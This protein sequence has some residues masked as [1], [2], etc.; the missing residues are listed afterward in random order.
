[1][2]PL[3]PESLLKDQITALN[4]QA[5]AVAQTFPDNLVK[6]PRSDWP[7]DAP[8]STDSIYQ[9]NRYYVQVHSE[10]AGVKRLCICKFSLDENAQAHNDISFSQIMGIKKELGM[11]DQD[12]A[13]VFPRES[14]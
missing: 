2:N 12:M 7:L 14:D 8:N 10:E 6:I 13:E 9:S 1:M 4:V 5:E 11:G 3:P